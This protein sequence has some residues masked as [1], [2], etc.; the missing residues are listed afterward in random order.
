M[1]TVKLSHPV[2]IGPQLYSALTFRPIKFGDVPMIIKAGSLADLDDVVRLVAQ[3]ADVP[4]EVACNIDPEDIAPVLTALTEHV[5]NR[6]PNI[7]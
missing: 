7:Q 4:L 2:A 1:T 3:L 6:M 5:A